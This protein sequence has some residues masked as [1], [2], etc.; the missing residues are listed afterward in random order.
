MACGS[1]QVLSDWRRHDYAPQPQ[2]GSPTRD[3]ERV[4]PPHV[5]VRYPFRRVPRT[6][7][8][9]REGNALISGLRDVASPQ[10]QAPFSP[11]N[12]GSTFPDS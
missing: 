4:R 5:T 9:M 3:A 12:A 10:I 8:T 1:I 11:R 2:L 6:R 7:L